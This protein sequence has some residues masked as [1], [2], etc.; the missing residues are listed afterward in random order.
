VE[1]LD[2][3]LTEEADEFGRFLVAGVPAGRI[4]VR[5]AP[6]DGPALVTPWLEA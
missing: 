4:R 2:G 5:C 6:A 1:H 3:S